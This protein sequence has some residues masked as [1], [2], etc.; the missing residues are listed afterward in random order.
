MS[1]IVDMDGNVPNDASTNR[2]KSCEKLFKSLETVEEAKHFITFNAASEQSQHESFEIILHGRACR[3]VP[4]PS[5]E[6]SYVILDA[7][8]RH[9]QVELI[10]YCLAE[11]LAPPNVTNLHAHST[12]DEKARVSI[13]RRSIPGASNT[14]HSPFF[15][16]SF[17][18]IIRR[19]W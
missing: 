4:V 5:R 10:Q 2:F 12:D 11:C 19:S 8:S 9:V 3:V 18:G 6:G 14:N 7:L 17:F 16:Y 1:A 13:S 15:S